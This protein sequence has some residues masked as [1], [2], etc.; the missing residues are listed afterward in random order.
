MA[1]LDAEQRVTVLLSASKSY[2]EVKEE[3]ST[4]ERVEV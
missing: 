4:L 2:E 3:L 1:V